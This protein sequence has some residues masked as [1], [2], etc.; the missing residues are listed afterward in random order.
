MDKQTAKKSYQFDL[1]QD[2]KLLT[3][4]RLAEDGEKVEASTTAKIADLNPELFDYAAGHGIKQK[5]T[6]DTME[7]KLNG[8][9]RLEVVKE[10]WDRIVA[11]TWD[12]PREGFVRFS[13]A[14]VTFVMRRK[15]I[16]RAEALASLEAAGKERVEAIKAGN[17][18]EIEKIAKELGE[19]RKGATAVDLTT[20]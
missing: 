9:D 6:D 5:L 3:I 17:A 10:T 16:T 1:S 4:R 2:G 11:G 14:L 12:K 7:N 13:E 8:R 19:T 20:L 18:A 15:K